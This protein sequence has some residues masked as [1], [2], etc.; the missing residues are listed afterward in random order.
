[1]DVFRML[2]GVCLVIISIIIFIIQIN[3]K[4]YTKDEFNMGNVNIYYVGI[5]SLLLGL[6][7]FIT[8]F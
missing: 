8:S 6:Y 3:N 2:M 4:A 5:A 1:M 7:L